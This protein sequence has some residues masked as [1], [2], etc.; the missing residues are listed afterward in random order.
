MLVCN[1]YIKQI[2]AITSYF[3]L[4]NIDLLQIRCNG[5]AFPV[6]YSCNDNVMH[7]FKKIEYDNGNVIPR[8]IK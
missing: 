7:Y 3:A 2:V 5:N 4:L 1:T 6:L 8:S